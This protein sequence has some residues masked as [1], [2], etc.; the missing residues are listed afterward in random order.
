MRPLNL[1]NCDWI[2]LS[3]FIQNIDANRQWSGKRSHLNQTSLQSFWRGI[4]QTRDPRNDSLKVGSREATQ[5]LA[6]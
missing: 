6:T 1:G 5:P 2:W 4:L 3:I